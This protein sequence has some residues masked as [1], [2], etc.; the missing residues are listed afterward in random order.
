MGVFTKEFTGSSGASVIFDYDAVGTGDREQKL[1][2]LTDLVIKA[3]NMNAEYGLRLPGRAIAP[4][5]G[6]RHRHA[7]L[8]ALALFDLKT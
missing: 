1:S 8:K 5:K 6:E 4:G 3:H 7:C 2:R